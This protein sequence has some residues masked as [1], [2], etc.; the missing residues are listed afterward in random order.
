MRGVRWV[1]LQ[2]SIDHIQRIILAKAYMS[3]AKVTRPSPVRRSTRKT[4]K[5]FREAEGSREQGHPSSAHRLPPSIEN[6]FKKMMQTDSKKNT[7]QLLGEMEL[8]LRSQC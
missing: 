8:A 1:A 7:L 2:S 5:I 6:N 4:K 3:S